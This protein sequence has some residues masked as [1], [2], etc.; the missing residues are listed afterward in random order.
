M[1]TSAA[2]EIVR[3]PFLVL[4]GREGDKL[5][6]TYD[7]RLVNPTAATLENVTTNTGGFFS[8]PDAGVVDATGKKHE[9]GNVG[10]GCA[11]CI[12]NPD[13]DELYEFV[14]WWEL[15]YWD[16]IV[17]SQFALHKFRSGVEISDVPIVGGKG[18]LLPRSA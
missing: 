17:R 7:L 11:I 18:I 16:P 1:K 13:L 12:E 4:V 9:F 10:P 5:W 3:E 14:I 8:D 6:P 2:E 15:T